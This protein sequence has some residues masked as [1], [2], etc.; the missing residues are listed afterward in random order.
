MSKICKLAIIAFLPLAMLVA[1]V[2][3]PSNTGS[4]RIVRAD[5]GTSQRILT[6]EEGDVYRPCEGLTLIEFEQPVQPGPASRTVNGIT[7][8]ITVNAAINEVDFTVSGGLVY[9]VIIKASY[10]SY[11]YT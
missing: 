4:T 3:A 2:F 10:I 1:S 5:H 8:N 9:Q 11:I 6:T 7:V